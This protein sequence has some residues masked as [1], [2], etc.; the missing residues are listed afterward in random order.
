MK[1][2]NELPDGLF[3]NLEEDEDTPAVCVEHQRFLPCRTCLYQIPATRAYSND[4]G[5]VQVIR[6][7][8]SP[9]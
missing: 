4:P 5:D 6:D 1:A 9:K 7:F 3:A 8:H 2:M